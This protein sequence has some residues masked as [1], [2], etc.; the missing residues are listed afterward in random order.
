MNKYEEA[1]QR[2]LEFLKELGVR[3]CGVNAR[4]LATYILAPIYENEVLSIDDMLSNDYL[5]VHEIIE[6]LALKSMGYSITSNIVIEAYPGTYKAH[7]KALRFELQLAIDCA[8]QEL[9]DILRRCKA[10]GPHRWN[11][12]L[13]SVIEAI[14]VMGRGKVGIHL[15]VGLGETE[16]EA[17]GLIRWTHDIGAET[18]L[19]S[20]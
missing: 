18:H 10:R 4:E 6:I 5:V 19:F 16:K 3:E 13:K 15:I 2:G 1:L 8:S 11:R 7:L 9:F 14:E 17:V 20:F 12:Y